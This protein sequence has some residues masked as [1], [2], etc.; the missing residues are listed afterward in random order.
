MI[1]KLLTRD[2]PRE[3][4][5]TRIDIR[6]LDKVEN[7][8]FELSDNVACLSCKAKSA[9]KRECNEKILRVCSSGRTITI[10][11]HEDYLNQFNG[12]QIAKNGRCDLLMFDA[13]EY[14]KVVF[15]DLACYSEKYVEKKRAKAHQ[16][17]CDSLARFYVKPSGKQF[18]DRFDDKVLVFGR[19]DRT[20]APDVPSAPKR[21][22]V[23]GNL[24]SFLKSPISTRSFAE[25]KEVV[26]GVEASFVIVNYP[27]AYTW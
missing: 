26:G 8:D 21:G 16:Q 7:A 11:E 19:R 15:C 17:V 27:N 5:L 24:V 23:R 12:L 22:D 6:L 25:S 1:K 13:A 14:H 9:D 4:G 2:L 20:V 18:I 10:V 3:Y